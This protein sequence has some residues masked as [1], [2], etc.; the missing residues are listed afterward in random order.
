[1]RV[2]TILA[3]KGRSV[4]T[5]APGAAVADVVATL[6]ELRIGA[7]VVSDGRNGI[8]GIVTERDVVRALAA[9]GASAL[10]RP[11]SDFM[12]RDVVTCHFEDTIDE[13]MDRMTRGKFRHIPVVDGV[14]LAG[15]ISIGDVVKHRLESIEAEASAMRDYIATA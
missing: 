3:A 4:T 14:A 15:I 2:S 5:V 13:M 11:V 9:H 8:A 1:M 12:T 7:V 6:A 10:E